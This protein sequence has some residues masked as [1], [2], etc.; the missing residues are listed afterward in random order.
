MHL[1]VCAS[2]HLN[3]QWCTYYSLKQ[4][5]HVDNSCQEIVSR[6]VRETKLVNHL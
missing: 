2:C 1:G 4:C 5:T 3:L 6:P